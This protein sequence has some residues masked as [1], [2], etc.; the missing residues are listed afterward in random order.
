MISDV[1]LSLVPAASPSNWNHGVTANPNLLLSP[2]QL[3]FPAKIKTTQLIG[4][5]N[6]PK[7]SGGIGIS[8]KRKDKKAPAGPGASEEKKYVS[9]KVYPQAE[10]YL[11]GR[12]SR[13]WLETLV[14][15]FQKQNVLEQDT[16]DRPYGGFFVVKVKVHF[17]PDVRP[18]LYRFRQKV[19]N[20]RIANFYRVTQMMDPVKTEHPRLCIIWPPQ[21]AQARFIVLGNFPTDAGTDRLIV[22]PCPGTHLAPDRKTE[23]QHNRYHK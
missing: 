11:T 15:V 1:T 14:L 12:R 22:T 17:R 16:G 10:Y 2:E 23:K 13:V 20:Q 7:M 5:R 4:R 19:Q 8:I 21:H 3:L 6:S 18:R 9:L